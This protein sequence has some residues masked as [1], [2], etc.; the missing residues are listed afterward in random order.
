MLGTYY[1]NRTFRRDRLCEFKSLLYYL[2]PPSIDDLGDETQ[3]LGFCC[4]ECARGVGELSCEGEVS[5]YFCDV[6]EGSE[7]GCETDVDF[8]HL[9]EGRKKSDDVHT[10]MENTASWAAYLISQADI[11]SM[12]SPMTGPCT[13]AMTGKRHRSGATMAC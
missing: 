3:F 1:R 13:A 10:L 5:G 11:R 9:L 6:S 7:V 2:I 12:P 8:L 4:C